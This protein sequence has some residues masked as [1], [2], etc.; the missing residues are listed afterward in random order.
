MNNLQ[1]IEAGL[2]TMA[3]VSLVFAFVG[4]FAQALSNE[5]WS[6][7]FHS[8]LIV[9][10]VIGMISATLFLALLKYTETQK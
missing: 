10:V 1:L 9:S 6:K 8:L 5:K 7:R 2:L 4:A 3:L